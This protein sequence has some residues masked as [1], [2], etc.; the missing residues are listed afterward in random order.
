MFATS[1]RSFASRELTVYSVGFISDYW[2][3]QMRITTPIPWMFVLRFQKHF[4]SQ[5]SIVYPQSLMKE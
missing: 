2:R 1:L 5:K 3:V 4:K